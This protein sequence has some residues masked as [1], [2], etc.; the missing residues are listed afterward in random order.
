MRKLTN[1]EIRQK[2]KELDGWQL[3]GDSIKKEWE[4]E[5][6]NEAMD[7]IRDVA[8]VVDEYDHHPELFNVYNKVSLTFTTHDAGG[9]TDK[10]FEVASEIDDI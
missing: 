1:E 9:L 3:D 10:D 2:L 4:F 5:D 7:F 6:F 8:D